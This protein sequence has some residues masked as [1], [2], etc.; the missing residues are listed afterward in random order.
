VSQE[1]AGPTLPRRL[2]EL[3][4][5]RPR[6]IAMQEKR[7]GIWHP[8]TWADHAARVRDFAGGLA[9]LGVRRGDAVGVIGDNR[10]EWLIAELAA[11]CLGAAAVGI[12][13][14]SADDELVDVLETAAVRVVVVD[15]PERIAKLARITGRLG[16]P[17]QIIHWDPHGLGHDPTGRVAR[18][19][20]VVAAGRRD[21]AARPGWLNGEIA[22]GRAADIAVLCAAAADAPRRL[23]RLSH[24]SLFAMA[25]QLH[26]GDAPQA[27]PR[28]VSVLP[29]AG[30]GEQ[31]VSV[32]YALAHGGTLAFPEDAATTHA[33][34]REIGPDI[35]L[36]PPRLWEHLKASV[37]GRIGGAGWLGQRVLRW[38]VAVGEAIAD[39]RARGAAAGPHLAAAHRIADA[40]ALGA[41]RDHLGLSRIRRGYAAGAPLSPDVARFFHAIGVELTEVPLREPA[42][43][44]GLRDDRGN[45]AAEAAGR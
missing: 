40:V 33:D 17:P 38:A 1:P 3:A 24:A 15:D 14:T 26:A 29:L 31:V 21:T 19:T 36:G 16:D 18:F 9:T 30:I 6:A 32:A 12:E 25:A 43:L 34:L 37:Q 5:A 7:Y 23:V 11:Q 35:L 27:G 42:E 45:I 41:I 20:D 28:Q 44:P 39:G 22:A 4:A 8:I 2:A 10:P 13:P